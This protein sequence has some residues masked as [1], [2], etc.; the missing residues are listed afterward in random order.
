MRL[1][2]YK[3]FLFC[4]FI[5]V[6]LVSYG[7][8]CEWFFNQQKYFNEDSKRL[9]VMKQ[10]NRSF[11]FAVL[12]SSRGDGAFDMPLLDSLLQI[13]GVNIASDGSGYVDN[14]LILN[15]FLQNNNKIRYLFLQ[16]DI[17]A[18]D[19]VRNFSNAFHVHNFLPFWKEEMYKNTIEHY[20]DSTDRFL[21]NAVPSLR[22]YKYNKYYSPYEVV[23][24]IINAKQISAQ[25][26]NVYYSNSVAPSKIDSSKIIK[27]SN[28]RSF[29]IEPF[30]E[31]YLVK[32]FEL[33][34]INKIEVICFKAPDFFFQEQV[35]TNYSKT[36]LYLEQLLFKKNK[37]YIKPAQNI[38]TNL[39]C[40]KDAGHLTNYGRYLFTHSAAE[41]FKKVLKL[42]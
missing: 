4:I 36:E 23:R 35:F 26:K 25:Y 31:A 12:G 6:L 33:C 29:S 40:F 11:D 5:V 18:L 24:R 21:F 14:Y 30:D 8:F 9:W 27:Q 16:T 19:P 28:S 20:L 7:W 38:R 10:K 3:G 34:E 15:K 39:Y 32:I 42:K 1:F 17:Y 2:F 37:T 22:F 41:Q 13:K